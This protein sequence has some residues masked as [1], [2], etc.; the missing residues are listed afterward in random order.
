MLWQRGIEDVKS[1]GK[2]EKQGGTI[3]LLILK[4]RQGPK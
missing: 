3:H 4:I 2:S 1:V